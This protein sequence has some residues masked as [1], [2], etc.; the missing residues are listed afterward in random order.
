MFNVVFFSFTKVASREAEAALMCRLGCLRAV[1]QSKARA[2]VPIDLNDRRTCNFNV[3]KK[4]IQQYFTGQQLGI[5]Q[6][7]FRIDHNWHPKLDLHV[8]VDFLRKEK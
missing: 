1:G 8:M 6:S 5:D 3:P 2:K 7:V 4:I